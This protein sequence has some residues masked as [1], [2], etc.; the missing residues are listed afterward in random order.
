MTTDEFANP[1]EFL[2]EL[3]KDNRYVDR[4]IVRVAECRR[5]S[6][7]SPVLLISVVG[8][9]RVGADIYRFEYICGSLCGIEVN[10]WRALAKMHKQ[11]KSLRNNGA[12]LGL[13]VRS[14]V[15]EESAL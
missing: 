14:E 10:D 15:L 1:S 9:A 6:G 8:T 7:M 13:D 4:G 5:A 3:R 11:L 2:A 12:G